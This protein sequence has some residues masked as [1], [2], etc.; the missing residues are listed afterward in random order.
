[1]AVRCRK[2]AAPNDERP[3]GATGG[4]S[5]AP[6]FV[7]ASHEEGVSMNVRLGG[8]ASQA[9]GRPPW[10]ALAGLLALSVVLTVWAVPGLAAPLSTAAAVLGGLATVYATARGKGQHGGR[11]TVA[12]ESEHRPRESEAEPPAVSPRSLR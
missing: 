6:K 7:N 9:S 4:R 11:S 12:S 3:L 1:M 10:T 2:V 5:F 8:R